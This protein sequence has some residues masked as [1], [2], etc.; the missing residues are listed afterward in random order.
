MQHGVGEHVNKVNLSALSARPVS[1]RYNPLS[2]TKG[3]SLNATLPRD[4][5]EASA[6]SN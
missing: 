1:A 3:Y 2:I 4:D 6:L 5:G